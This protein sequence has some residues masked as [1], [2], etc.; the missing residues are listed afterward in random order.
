V[1]LPPRPLSVLVAGGPGREEKQC[2]GATGKGTAMA[3]LVIRIRMENA[4]FAD[5][6]G[7]AAGESA[8]VA[9]ILRVYCAAL[10]QIDMT[11]RETKLRD[12]NGNTVGS[13]TVED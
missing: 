4:A 7:E 12:V 3:T 11:P 6:K 2:R 9:R 13:A 10:D 1:R 8:E 5:N